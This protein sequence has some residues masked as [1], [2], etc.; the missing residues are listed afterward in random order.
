MGW[1]NEPFMLMCAPA[2]GAP[3][4]LKTCQ[5]IAA[6]AELLARATPPRDKAATTT[7][8]TKAMRALFRAV[9]SSR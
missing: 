8:Q 1:P 5:S 9:P 6:V 2:A 4:A 3:A 7:R